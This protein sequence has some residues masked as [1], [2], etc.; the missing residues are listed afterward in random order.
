[1]V[2]RRSIDGAPYT[3]T[4][5][6]RGWQVTAASSRTDRFHRSYQVVTTSQG[7]PLRCTCPH[8]FHSASWCKHL[9]E[10]EIIYRETHPEV[11]QQPEAE[12]ARCGYGD[13][14]VVIH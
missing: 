7:E 8:C 12:A 4:P 11:S 1:M 13:E 9:R 14:P 5:N 2:L 10:A 3:F 6:A